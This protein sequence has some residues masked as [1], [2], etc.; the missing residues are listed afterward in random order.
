MP[1]LVAHHDVKDVEHWLA[2]SKRAEIFGKMGVENIRTFVDPTNSSHV[3]LM[4]DVPDVDALNAFMQT[5]EAAAAMESD[6]VLPETLTML[7]E[8]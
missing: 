3:A 6:G 1:T 5:P 4:M 7:I 8:A 2:S